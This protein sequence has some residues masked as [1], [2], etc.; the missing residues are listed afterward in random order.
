MTRWLRRALARWLAPEIE[1][2]LARMA[3]LG[4]RRFP[5]PVAAVSPSGE[6]RSL[7]RDKA[8]RVAEARASVAEDDA[9][10]RATLRRSAEAQADAAVAARE[11]ELCGLTLK[12]FRDLAAAYRAIRS[13]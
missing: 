13:G 8:A 2:E 12:E 6:L 7:A 10:R 1:V 11:R 3:F 5:R 4:A 9:E